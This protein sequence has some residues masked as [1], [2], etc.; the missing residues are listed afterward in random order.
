LAFFLQHQV[1]VLFG[2]VKAD[3][4]PHTPRLGDIMPK[5]YRR[6]IVWSLVVQVLLFLLASITFD[7]GETFV[8]FTY[9][10]VAYWI[11]VAMILRRRS[12]ELI[13][14]DVFYLKYGL[15]V[16]SLVSWNLSP[17]IWALRGKGSY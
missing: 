13:R 11:G 9:S 4:T 6:Y 15:I 17:M 3:N 1:R 10:A 16:L 14:T 12:N 7:Y 8:A 2:A 5:P